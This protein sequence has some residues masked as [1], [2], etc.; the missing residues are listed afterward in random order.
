[1]V[2]LLSENYVGVFRELIPTMDF[3]DYEVKVATS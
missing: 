2:A 1:M 3:R